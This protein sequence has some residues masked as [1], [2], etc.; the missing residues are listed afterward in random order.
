MMQALTPL[1]AVLVAL[2]QAEGRTS[3]P[4]TASKPGRTPTGELRIDSGAIRGLVVGPK[5]DVQV[6]KGIP[7]AAP[8]VGELRWKPPQPVRPWQGVRDCFEFGAACPQKVS[9]LLSS[10]PEMALGVPQSEDCLYLNVWTPAER[11]AEKLPVLYWIHGGGFVLGAASQPIYDGEELARLGCVVVSINYRL[12]LFGFLAHPALS[13][14]SSEKV[15]GNYGLLDQ[16]EGL[17]WVKRNIA[18]FGGDPDRVTIFGESAGGISVL[19]LM[20]APEAAGLLHGAIAQSATGMNPTPL[21]NANPGQESAEQAGQ[22]FLAACGMAASADAEQMRRL[23]VKVL[24]QAAPTEATPGAPVQLKPLALRLGPVVDGHVIPDKPNLLFAAG[25]EH[26][27]PMI[28]GNTRDEMSLFVLTSKLPADEAAYRKR[29]KE[30]FGDLADSLVT[31]YPAKDAKEIRSAV[32]QFTS[33]LS[34]VSES[35]TIA[36]T[37]TAAGQK[38]FRYQFSRGTRRGFLQGLGAHH[39]AELPFVFQRSAGHDESEKRTARTMGHYWINFAATGDP[40]GKGVPEWP[41]YRADTE[42]VLDFGENVSVLKG[43]RNSQLDVIEKALRATA[44]TATPKV[45]H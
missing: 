9:L 10:I 17:R 18:A 26:P 19:C 12:G 36:R 11:K 35:R 31:A 14:E 23:D 32:V 25:R 15:S 42:D 27:V 45:Q 6:Y 20:V 34:F 16:I 39:G 13:Q 3:R 38:T 7:F 22:R 2:S 28:V 21:R 24:V 4:R 37:H 44:D 1:L 8:P 5:K 33:E 43:P 41:V 40:N 29:L 30:D